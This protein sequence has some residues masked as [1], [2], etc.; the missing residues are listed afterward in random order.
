MCPLF[1]RRPLY[2][3][4]NVSLVVFESVVAQQFVLLSVVWKVRACVCG[5]NQHIVLLHLQ[6][7]PSGRHHAPPCQQTTNTRH[8]TRVVCFTRGT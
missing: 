6:H 7:H 2:V 5:Q 4:P 8:T 1:V 3:T